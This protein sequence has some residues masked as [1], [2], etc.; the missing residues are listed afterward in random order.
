MS[1]RHIFTWEM[2]RGCGV[3]SQPMVRSVLGCDAMHVWGCVAW[4]GLG[5]VRFFLPTLMDAA[6]RHVSCPHVRRLSDSCL[7]PSLVVSY[8]V[9]RC[10][11]WWRGCCST[12]CLPVIDCSN[13]STRTHTQGDFLYSCHHIHGVSTAPRSPDPRRGGGQFCCIRGAC[14]S[15]HP[16]IHALAEWLDGLCRMPFR[17]LYTDPIDI[18]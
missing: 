5:G 14:V 15:I 2:G 17:C 7:P 16:S 8:R 12:Q 18:L 1:A 10:V 4:R 9:D 6:E 11:A 3:C 13:G